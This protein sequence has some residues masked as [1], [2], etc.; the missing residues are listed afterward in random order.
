MKLNKVLEAATLL[1]QG[2]VAGLTLA[3]MYTIVLAE[4]LESF[5]TSYEVCVRTDKHMETCG[6]SLCYFA[7]RVLALPVCS[8][9]PKPCTSVRGKYE[10]WS[11]L[12]FGRCKVVCKQTNRS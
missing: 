11:N 1:V 10:G 8:A 5:V 6:Q 4:S 2:A 7:H 12:G 3:S 9:S